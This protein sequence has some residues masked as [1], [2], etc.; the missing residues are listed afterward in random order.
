MLPD[1][2]VSARATFLDGLRNHTLLF[3]Y[4]RE[5]EAP[6]FYPREIGPSGL[7]S[8][9]EWRRSSG[10]GTVYSVTVVYA[11]GREPYN[12]ALIALEEG[13]RM[14]ATVVDVDPETVTIGQL[15]Q[16]DYDEVDGTPRA[17]FR[18]IA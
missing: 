10:R 14:M 12:V 3:Q 13:F 5:V 15:V 4:D 18:V 2:F 6:V 17:V 9:L 1:T 7:R 8:T 11:K 16:A